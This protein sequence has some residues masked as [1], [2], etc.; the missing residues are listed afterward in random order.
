MKEYKLYY[1]K[2]ID[3]SQCNGWVLKEDLEDLSMDIVS[4]GHLI[5]ETDNFIVLSAHVGKDCICSPIQIPKVAI[6][7]MEEINHGQANS[8]QAQ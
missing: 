2:W 6:V 5:K 7:S 8:S 3:S 4:C 1:V